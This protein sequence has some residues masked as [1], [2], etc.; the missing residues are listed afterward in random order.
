MAPPEG[1][2]LDL[3]RRALLLLAV[4]ALAGSGLGIAARASGL[5]PMQ[6]R[7]SSMSP[8]IQLGRLDPRAQAHRARSARD[9][10]R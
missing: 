2:R 3:M 7:S 5:S 4:A 1:H 6:V 9:R 10:A 8:A